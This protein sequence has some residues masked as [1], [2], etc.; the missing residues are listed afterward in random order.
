MSDGEN[1]KKPIVDLVLLYRWNGRCGR[2]HFTMCYFV[3]KSAKTETDRK[4]SPK[5]FEDYHR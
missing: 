1:N 4:T 2:K 5:K 3:M